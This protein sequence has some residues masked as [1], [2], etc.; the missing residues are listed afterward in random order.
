MNVN[1]TL[2]PMTAADVDAVLLLE[3]KTLEAPH[4]GRVEYERCIAA[5]DREGLQRAGFVA[6]ADD[7]L[8]GFAIGKLVAGICEL[9]S[10]AVEEK[11]RGQGI[12]HALLRAVADWAM[13]H[14]ASRVELEVRASNVR[15]IRL[16]EQTGMR[17]EGVRA[18]YY[19]SPDEDAVLMGADINVLPALGGK[20]L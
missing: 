3:Q 16:Y 10:I 17:R 12:G 6:E 9:E 19:Q 15:A 5:V 2:R 7:S 8:I 14:G 1:W 18:R 13:A 4:W 20:L 11:A